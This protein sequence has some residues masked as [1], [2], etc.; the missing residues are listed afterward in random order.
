MDLD[1]LDSLCAHALRAPTAGNSAGVRMYTAAKEEVSGYFAV[2]TDE[3]WRESSRPF[4]GIARAGALILVTSRPQDYLE[5]YCEFD[6]ATSQLNRRENWTVPY[7][8]TD[9]AMATMS[10]LLLLEECELGAV[11]W[12]NFRNNAAVM[13]WANITDEELFAT[14]LVGTAGGEEVPS[15]SLARHVPPRAERVQR[16]RGR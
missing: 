8:H 1:L 2:A 11:M 9:A 6:K 16:I 3:K 10:L 4:A 7:W 15:R 14:V 5:R 13:Q 12:G